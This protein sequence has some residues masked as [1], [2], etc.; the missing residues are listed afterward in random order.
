MS[1]LDQAQLMNT[2]HGSNP[3]SH[4]IGS[5]LGTCS[6]QRWSVYLKE[7]S[8]PKFTYPMIALQIAGPAKIYRTNRKKKLSADYVM[9]GDIAIIP[10]DQALGWS[11]NGQVDVAVLIFEN[12]NTRNSIEK[13]YKN[14]QTQK[15]D[16]NRVGSFSDPYLFSVCNHLLNIFDSEQIETPDKNYINTA[17]LALENYIVTYFGNDKVPTNYSGKKLSHPVSYTIKRLNHEL[18]HAPQISFIADELKLT[19]AFL[20]KK[21]KNETGVSPYQFLLLLRI[22]RAKQFLI[23]TDISISDIADET[24]FCS[25]AHMTRHFSKIVGI[26]PLKFRQHSKN[27]ISKFS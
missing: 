20:T 5:G 12:L 18:S 26:T 27:K 9:S 6:L 14:I 13:V 19:Q 4:I 23:E 24:G 25:Q 21:F 22:K 8:I 16:S 10:A 2:I 11:I 15:G 7:H 1:I 3:I 17:F